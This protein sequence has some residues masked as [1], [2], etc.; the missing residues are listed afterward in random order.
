MKTKKVV[1]QKLGNFGN[2]GNTIPSFLISE[3]SIDRYITALKQRDTLLNS[4][5]DTTSLKSFKVNFKRWIPEN[6]P[7]DYLK[8]IFNV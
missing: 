3:F 6:C 2:F 7:A 8:H 1:N 5:K 4:C